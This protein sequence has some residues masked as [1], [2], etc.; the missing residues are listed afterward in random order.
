VRSRGVPTGVERQHDVAREQDV[1][2]RA[3]G[4]TSRP[5]RMSKVGPALLLTVGALSGAVLAWVG[6]TSGGGV[7][8]H[9]SAKL[10]SREPLMRVTVRD[11][12]S[13]SSPTLLSPT[14][15]LGATPDILV[16]EPEFEPLV[17]RLP[18]PEQRLEPLMSMPPSSLDEAPAIAAV[19]P[20][21]PPLAWPLGALP[22][23]ELA[24]AEPSLLQQPKHEPEPARLDP[25][26]EL[27]HMQRP[28]PTAA[29]APE[30]EQQLAMAPAAL[31]PQA[32]PPQQSR[33]RRVTVARARPLPVASRK[34]GKLSREPARQVSPT[35]AAATATP[36]ESSPFRKLLERNP[37]R[38]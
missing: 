35:R 17:R 27:E 36:F 26:P 7:P 9:E 37:Y 15:A 33:V 34:P 14:G 19:G 32:Q 28:V 29:R 38:R 31:A 21:V 12:S 5:G 20:H 4:S 3:T 2:A 10:A 24:V 1:E 25:R 30:P 18:E 6:P 8:V 13:P 11:V 23:V 16:E 22:T